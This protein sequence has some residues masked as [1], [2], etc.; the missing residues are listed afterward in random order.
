MATRRWRQAWDQ[1]EPQKIERQ[2]R[3]DGVLTIFPHLQYSQSYPVWPKIGTVEEPVVMG[4]SSL[5][6]FQILADRSKTFF[7]ISRLPRT[8]SVFRIEP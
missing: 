4:R 6:Q 8:E 1:T 7:S 5:L 2:E 3:V